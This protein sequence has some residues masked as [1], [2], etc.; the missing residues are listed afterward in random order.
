M[1]WR[2]GIQYMNLGEGHIQSTMGQIPNSLPWA[3]KSTVEIVQLWQC[4][5]IKLPNQ[6]IYIG[7]M[8]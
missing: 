3:G 2:L 1:L 8:G 5:K 6:K 4:K 7:G